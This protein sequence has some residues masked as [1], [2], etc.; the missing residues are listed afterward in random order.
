MTSKSSGLKPPPMTIAAG[1]APLWL[2]RPEAGVTLWPRRRDGISETA[3]ALEVHMWVT[4]EM[5]NTLDSTGQKRDHSPSY[6]GAN[7]F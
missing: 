6:L 2:P 4:V 1:N 3:V 5:R 7:N